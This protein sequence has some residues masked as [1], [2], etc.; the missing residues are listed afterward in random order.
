MRVRVFV[1][2]WNFQIEWNQYHRARGNGLQRIPWSGVLPSVLTGHVDQNGSYS[3]THVYASIDPYN[4][5]DAKLRRFLNVMDGFPGYKVILKER[6]ARS[7]LKCNHEDCRK[8]VDTCPACGRKVSRTVEK[9]VDTALVTDLIQ[10]AVDN[11]FDSA[12]LITADADFIPAVEFIQNRTEKRIVHTY[13]RQGGHDLRNACW[14]HLHLDD[15]MGELLP[16]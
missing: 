7:P 8:P 6:K 15:M 12:V 11:M 5:K 10:L 14:T 13:F 3:G 4:P 2:F 9:G 1:D 16:G